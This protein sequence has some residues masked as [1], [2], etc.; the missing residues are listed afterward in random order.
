MY[1]LQTFLLMIF[2][3]TTKFDTLV[4]S[5]SQQ[6]V[7]WFPHQTDAK[8]LHPIL[9]H[10]RHVQIADAERAVAELNKTKTLWVCIDGSVCDLWNLHLQCSRCRFGG[11]ILKRKYTCLWWR[12][13]HIFLVNSNHF[14]FKQT[15][16]PKSSIPSLSLSLW[17][18]QEFSSKLMLLRFPLG[19]FMALAAGTE[20]PVFNIY[21]TDHPCLHQS[22]CALHHFVEETP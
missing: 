19:G 1:T 10:Y 2:R 9:W 20:Y 6:P 8:I 11:A 17:N 12:F 5:P 14:I 13:P 15:W 4:A 7:L 3:M 18:L 16:S 21:A 22:H